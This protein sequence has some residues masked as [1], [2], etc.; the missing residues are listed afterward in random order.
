MAVLDKN[1]TEYLW[2]KAKEKFAAKDDVPETPEGVVLYT[3]QSLTDDQKTQARGNIGAVGT[4]ESTEEVY[5]YVFTGEEETAGDG[6]LSSYAK[7]LDDVTPDFVRSLTGCKTNVPDMA[8]VGAGEMTEKTIGDVLT[9]YNDNVLILFYTEVDGAVVDEEFGGFILPKR[10]MYLLDALAVESGGAYQITSLTST[11][12]YTKTTQKIDEALIPAHAHSWEEL[13]DKPFKKS[14]IETQW[15]P[16]PDMG[17][18]LPYTL[19]FSDSGPA[20]GAYFEFLT[21]PNASDK[22]KIYFDG[23][24]YSDISLFG[25]DTDGN[26]VP[27]TDGNS[28]YC[29]DASILGIPVEDATGLPFLLNIEPSQNFA[30]FFATDTAPSH[31]VALWITKDVEDVVECLNIK[32]PSGKLFKLTVDDNGTITATEVV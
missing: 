12:P 20:M 3:E 5:T 13:E 24:T 15:F 1:G 16:Y 23:I 25:M 9:F 29:G 26:I 14:V 22:L 2:N 17:M 21:A 10:G 30:M 27:P 4:V 11:V 6:D 8:E 31:S 18:E 28:L 19:E 32:S 7:Y